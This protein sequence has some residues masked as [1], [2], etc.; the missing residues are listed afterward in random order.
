MNKKRLIVSILSVLLIGCL[1]GCND[2][3][4]NSG[5]NGEGIGENS[6]QYNDDTSNNLESN[7]KDMADNNVQFISDYS[8]YN[9]GAA[10][11]I[12]SS[13]DYTKV[14]LDFDSMERAP[15]CAVPNCT[16]NTS[17]C[18]SKNIGKFY[19]PVF[20]DGY[21]YYFASNGGAVKETSDGPE[22]YIDS[23]L[24]RASLDS[25]ETETVC[26]FH[27]AVPKENGGYVLYND[28]LFF[29]ADDRGA[30]LDDFGNFD[31][32]NS[33][34][35]FFLCSINLDTKEYK[36]YGSIYEKD[37]EYEGSEYSRS[38]NIYGI[39]NGKMY[40]SHA[41]VKDQSVSPDSDEYWTFV[42]FEFD[43]ETKTWVESELP[44]SRYMNEDCYIYYD[45][46]DKNVKAIYQENEY[47][48]ELGF[49]AM[50][51]L[52]SRC[53]EFN[54]KLF[55]PSIGIWYDL[56][57][58]SEHSMGEYDEYDAVAYYDGSYILVNG[59]KTVK[60]SEEELLGL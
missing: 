24:M 50:D 1:T 53:S 17:S 27:D 12:G 57:D 37:K 18:L 22:F 38:S 6:T 31:W 11:T 4:I 41:F 5:S 20:Y 26:E 8:Y 33:G 34:G 14:F 30:N 28:E 16:H 58:M 47:E 54:G 43:F 59:A 25:S 45:Y 2:N 21:V 23:S 10:Y 48:F 56:T 13:S 36:N 42:N 9:N 7:I 40:I 60:L 39:Y 32:G 46:D 29:V 49:T 3:S 52:D 51:Y 19:M 55:F 44:P 35:N 15:L